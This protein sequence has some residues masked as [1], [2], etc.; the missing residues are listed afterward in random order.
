MWLQL[1]VLS[2]TETYLIV[3]ILFSAVEYA[4]SAQLVGSGTCYVIS[5]E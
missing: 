5:Y 2:S 3:C 1:A 4:V